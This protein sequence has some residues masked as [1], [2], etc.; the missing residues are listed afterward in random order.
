MVISMSAFRCMAAVV[1]SLLVV[2]ACGPM[3]DEPEVKTF[4]QAVISGSAASPAQ[5][6]V[7][8]VNGC[9]GT[10]LTNRWLITAAHCIG[11][12]Q[13]NNPATLSVKLG[14]Q[15]RKAAEVVTHAKFNPATVNFA[16][17]PGDLAMVRLV[18]PMMINGSYSRH[19]LG[20]HVYDT[21]R[22][23][24]GTRVTC[25]GYGPVDL[26]K[27]GKG[28]LRRSNHRTEYSY[29][30]VEYFKL[31]PNNV[32]QIPMGGDSGGPCFSASGPRRIVGIVTRCI[33][34]RSCTA[35]T[36]NHMRKWAANVL[37]AR[38]IV[39]AHSGLV[40][41][42]PGRS[43]AHN[44]KLQQYPRNGGDHQRWR[45]NY[46]DGDLAR[47]HN[48]NSSK[49]LTVPGNKRHSVA[50]LVQ[51]NCG[52]GSGQ[53]WRVERSGAY[54]RLRSLYSGMCL[55]IPG[56]AKHAVWVQ[57]YPCHGGNSQRFIM[58]THPDE[59]AA[60]QLESRQYPGKCADVPS[61]TWQVHTGLQLYRCHQERN[62]RF[63]FSRRADGMY[64]MEP[65]H[66][67]PYR[68]L[69]PA[70]SRIQQYY[71][72][73]T[74]DQHFWLQLRRGGTHRVVSRAAYVCMEGV[75]NGSSYPLQHHA[76]GSRD[77]QMWHFKL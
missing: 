28:V 38:E 64:L 58:R 47:V 57:Q 8:N 33:S 70:G 3:E 72:R 26:A 65:L 77:S 10:M 67:Y 60:F 27:N 34:G 9:S 61:S 17:T 4:A 25:F 19:T 41:D 51:Q 1:P 48:V 11:S 32:G 18:S 35:E 37:M 69:E 42:V 24:V 22:V 36:S 40:L 43:K 6:P 71:Y 13:R 68:M 23:P 15:T 55:D 54:F 5:Y 59:G 53:K 56:G 16:V 63:R 50:H 29:W 12:G 30:G 49:C 76:C 45:L 14:G 44:V 66:A 74:T 75:K 2:V 52:N 73:G 39:N 7:A 20:F 62:Q 31:V 21:L 46:L